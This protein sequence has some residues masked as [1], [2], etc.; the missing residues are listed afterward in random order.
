LK[1]N[2][3]DHRIRT[4]TGGEGRR[5]EKGWGGKE[6]IGEIWEESSRGNGPIGGMHPGS[7]PNE[8]IIVY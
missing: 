8:L 1:G 6:E 4:K 7:L 3:E 5:G 2:N